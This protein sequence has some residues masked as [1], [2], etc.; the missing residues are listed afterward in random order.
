VLANDP[1]LELLFF[2][3]PRS[4]G[5]RV[6]TFFEFPDS[7]AKDRGCARFRVDHVRGIA[8]ARETFG[9]GVRLGAL[10]KCG[11]LDREPGAS[12]LIQL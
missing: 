11:D 12:G 6:A 4:H 3:Q 7:Y 8:F 1:G 9:Y 2:L 10:P 5:F